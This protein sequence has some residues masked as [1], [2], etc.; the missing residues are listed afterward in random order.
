MCGGELTQRPDDN[1]ESVRRRLAVYREQTAPVIDYYRRAGT[2]IEVDGEGPPDDV[3][4][5]LA[6]ARNRHALSDQPL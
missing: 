4:E 2:I 6:A 1:R 5:R 3:H